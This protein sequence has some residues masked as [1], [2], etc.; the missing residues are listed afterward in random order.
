[1]ALFSMRKRGAKGTVIETNPQAKLLP[2]APGSN[3]RRPASSLGTA[4]VN[5][6]KPVK[7]VGF[8]PGRIR[9][10]PA[11]KSMVQKRS[12][13]VASTPHWQTGKTGAGAQMPKTKSGAWLNVGKK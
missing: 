6:P 5:G 12:E 1:M 2:S 4:P 7:D 8:A 3:Y 9:K 10:N 11:G 13:D